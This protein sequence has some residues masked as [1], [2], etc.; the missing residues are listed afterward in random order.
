MAFDFLVSVIHAMPLALQ[1]MPSENKYFE[2]QT[3]TYFASVSAQEPPPLKL[4][5]LQSVT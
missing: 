2:L 1:L 5:K 4:N 3:Y